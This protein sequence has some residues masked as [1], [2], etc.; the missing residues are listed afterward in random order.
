ME[1]A[2]I[3][4]KALGYGKIYAA[5]VCGAEVVNPKIQ[6]TVDARAL[7]EMT[8]RWRKYDMSV[9]GPV[10]LDLAIS[11]EACR[12]KRYSAE[13]AGEADILLVPTYEVGN[14]IGKSMNYFGNGKNAGI[15]MGAKVP[16]VLVSRSDSSE[17]KL[18]S[19]AL[20]SIVAGKWTRLPV[21]NKNT[22]Q[23]NAGTRIAI[24][25][26]AFSVVPYCNLFSEELS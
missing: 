15:I 8:D 25:A 24:R 9:F 16:I 12:H 18:V 4:L 26:P 21:H 6:S 2:A 7:S 17:S 22:M 11:K 23:R 14:G 10:G 5:C 20:G 3:M 19:I 1:N 13:G